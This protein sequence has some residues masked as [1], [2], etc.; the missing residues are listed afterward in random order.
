LAGLIDRIRMIRRE[1]RVTQQIALT[2]FSSRTPD[3]SFDCC[4]V[5][6]CRLS[7]AEEGAQHLSSIGGLRSPNSPFPLEVA[8]R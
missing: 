5:R 7:S 6:Q 2:F 3:C 1:L 8:A 4:V